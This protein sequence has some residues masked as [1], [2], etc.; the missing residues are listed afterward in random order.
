M[1]LTDEQRELYQRA[2]KGGYLQQWEFNL[3]LSS[4]QAWKEEAERLRA[5][6]ERIANGSED[7]NGCINIDIEALTSTAKPTGAKRVKEQFEAH[8]DDVIYQMGVRDTISCLGIT[9]PGINAPEKE[10][11]LETGWS[12]RKSH[13][14]A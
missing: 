4:E 2:F 12:I 7:F 11:N 9:I 13:E 5:A 3:I 14:K 10:V 1:K 6:L 8:S